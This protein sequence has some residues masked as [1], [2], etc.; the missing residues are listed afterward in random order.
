MLAA[1]EIKSPAL[2]PV[3]HIPNPQTQNPNPKPQTLNP[4]TLTTL[5][6]KGSLKA[7]IPGVIRVSQNLHE[8]LLELACQMVE[9]NDP[10]LWV[11]PPPSNSLYLG[12][13]L[14]AT[15]NHIIIVIQLLLRGG[16]TQPKLLRP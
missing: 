1:L 11:L 10:K 15:Y 14:R 3:S 8:N 9:L 6:W 12:V 7:K 13:L 4:K 16:S 5:S 2:V